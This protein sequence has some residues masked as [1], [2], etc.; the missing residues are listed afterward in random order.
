MRHIDGCDKP[1]I[2]QDLLM[3]NAPN[4]VRLQAT[5]LE[6]DDRFNE[7]VPNPDVYADGNS[8]GAVTWFKTP[9]PADMQSR[10]DTSGEVVRAHGVPFEATPMPDGVA[11]TPTTAGSKRA[12]AT[13][14]IRHLLFDADGVVQVVPGGWY[15][16][17][18]PYLGDRAQEFLRKTWSDELPALRGVGDYLPLL[19]AALVEYGVSEP[20]D[21]VYRAV[22]HNIEVIEETFTIIEALRRDGYGVHLG[23][24]QEQRRGGHMRTVL[25]Y[26]DRFDTSCYSYDLGFAKPDPAFF[27]EAARRI[28]SE[29]STIL[30]IDDNP[31]NVEGA[32]EAGLRAAHW[33]VEHGHDALVALL[34]QHG[35]DARLTT[36]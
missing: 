22:W 1:V 2:V 34:A 9:L 24:N 3:P 18:E 12:V 23:T 32:R 5:Y 4:Y 14:S 35:V 29:P 17:M 30:F 10:V 15:A 27:T 21:V 25:G 19:A 6:I 7:H 8:V 11:L 26:D 31:P 28:G 20:V 33:G 36:D 16:S 13:S